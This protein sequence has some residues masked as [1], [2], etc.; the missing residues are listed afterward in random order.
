[1]ESGVKARLELL[2]GAMGSLGRIAP[3]YRHHAVG[4]GRVG[5]PFQL[6]GSH[7]YERGRLGA[8]FRLDGVS[9]RFFGQGSVSEE[10]DQDGHQNGSE[11]F[12]HEPPS[13]EC[14]SYEKVDPNT[15]P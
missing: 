1:M 5:A 7:G 2:E 12:H 9:F 6:V 10:D 13:L 15:Q 11:T 4:V 3:G 8:A 14:A